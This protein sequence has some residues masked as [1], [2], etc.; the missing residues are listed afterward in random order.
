MRCL[1]A[2]ILLAVIGCDDP[3]NTA[4]VR[5][6]IFEVRG[7]AP[8]LEGSTLELV[9]IGLERVGSNPLL[10][11]DAAAGTTLL[12]ATEA[13]NTYVMSGAGV[14]LLGSGIHDVSLTLQGDAG[15]SNTVA[16]TMS[17]AETLPLSLTEVPSGEVYRNE[18]AVLRG[19]G[20]IARGEGALVAHF[21]G[22]FKRDTDGS[23]SSLDVALPVT[24]AEQGQRD[25]GVVLLTTAL[26][27]LAPGTF[28]GTLTLEST[29]LNGS[30]SASDAVSTTFHFNPPVLF[31][32]DPARAALGQLVAVRGAGFLGGSGDETT[33]ISLDGQLTPEGGSPMSLS[34]ADLVPSFVS[35]SE[36]ALVLEPVESDGVLISETFGTGRGRFE[37]TATPIAFSGSE[38]LAG[39]PVP[40][41]FEIAGVRQVVYLRFLP[42]FYDSLALFGLS[43]AAPELEQAVVERIRSIYAGWA[44]EVRLDVPQ[45]YSPNAFS[46]VEIGGTDP[47]GRGLLG[48]D[49]TPGKD[50]G[51]LRL[52]DAIGGGNAET[53][54]D[55]YP[56][57]GGVFI[58][59][60][61]AWS[62]HPE[63]PGLESTPE[64]LFDPLFDPVRLTPAT[65]AEAEGQGDPGRV[66]EVRNAID[67]LGA[68][69]GE[70]TAHEIGH[71]LGMAQP[72]GQPT[73]FHNDF[74][75]P[76]CLMDTGRDRPFGER[77]A[78]S[79]FEPTR[80]CGDHPAYLDEILP[81]G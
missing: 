30:E 49:N 62:S 74:D 25:R 19:D 36:L 44:L 1:C 40:F 7:P 5:V 71:S 33:V 58:E 75:M 73:A 21:V 61:L 29:L 79:G 42:G 80:F 37:G 66:T 9:G 10:R 43:A 4:S 78:Q 81:G 57:Y 38:E 70:T 65:L 22:T 27:G 48:Y 77:A 3:S 53:Q 51:N 45:D 18:Q 39:A 46:V 26:G 24:L 67:A 56:G 59:S 54:D 17:V 60:F 64:P 35:G 52:F 69:I 15:R 13:D 31:D 11:L 8:L 47:N 68:I 16:Y 6:E 41:A 55:G 12:A 28:D 50:V 76:G 23:A 20:M 14:S 34:G 72:N 32:V 63:V 2:L